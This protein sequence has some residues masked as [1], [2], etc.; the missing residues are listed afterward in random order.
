ME[1]LDDRQSQL[2]SAY[3]LTGSAKVKG[4]VEFIETLVENK[5][6]FIVFCHHYEVMDQIEDAVVKKRINY[7]RIDGQIEATKRYEAVRRFQ[8][9]SNI[10]VGI[11]SLTASSQGITLTAATTVVFAEMN[12]TPGI[13]VQAED[14]CHRIGQINSVNVYYLFGEETVDAMIYPRLKLKSEVF[15][16]VLDGKRTEFTIDNEDEVQITMGPQQAKEAEEMGKL[17][18]RE[19]K[20]VERAMNQEPVKYTQTGMKDFFRG[21]RGDEEDRKDQLVAAGYGERQP[22]HAGNGEVAVDAQD[23]LIS[24]TKLPA[25]SKYTFVQ[26]NPDEV[27]GLPAPPLA[28]VNCNL[29]EA[30]EQTLVDVER[31]EWDEGTDD[32]W[33]AYQALRAERKKFYAEQKELAKHRERLRIRNDE[34]RAQQ[35]GE[36][37]IAKSDTKGEGY[38]VVKQE[39]TAAHADGLSEEGRK[40]LFQNYA[41]YRQRQND[42]WRQKINSYFAKKK[43][44]LIAAYAEY[45]DELGRCEQKFLERLPDSDPVLT[46]DRVEAIVGNLDNNH[47]TAA[48]MDAIR[49]VHG[50]EPNQE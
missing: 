24:P 20:M 4:T 41:S 33:K 50:Y 13:M 14:R 36:D 10:L 35:K 31:E 9:D 44:A 15:A 23:N 48:W 21:P 16:N 19:A 38:S 3:Q 49:E 29:N 45:R 39:A 18:A 22:Q 1:R 6:K 17:A 27:D 12:W 46:R 11:L 47:D 7:I 30:D 5:V 2:L 40:A 43:S 32:K 8:T 26:Y 42:R 34:E 28:G 25:N 37:N